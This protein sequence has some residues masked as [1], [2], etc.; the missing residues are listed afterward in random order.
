MLSI[1]LRGNLRAILK[2]TPFDK[3]ALKSHVT[4]WDHVTA[5]KPE[6]GVR[7][8]DVDGQLVAEL[9]EMRRRRTQFDPECIH[10][11]N[12]IMTEMQSLERGDDGRREFRG[13]LARL[14]A[15]LYQ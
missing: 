14:V 10:W 5:L 6:I 12:I 2:R 11:G 15:E 3:S 4:R 13:K 1:I 8:D 9:E 7:G